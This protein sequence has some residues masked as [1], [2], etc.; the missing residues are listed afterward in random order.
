VYDRVRP[1]DVR[2]IQLM[3]NTGGMKW[4]RHDRRVMESLRCP[5]APDGGVQVRAMGTTRTEPGGRWGLGEPSRDCW[6]PE[7][8][9]LV[10]VHR[11]EETDPPQEISGWWVARIQD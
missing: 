9:S 11:F 3:F 2:V 4:K 5:C 6:G 7:C 1:P 10:E 8:R